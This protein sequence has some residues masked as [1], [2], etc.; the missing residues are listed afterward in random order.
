[1]KKLKMKSKIPVL[2]DELYDFFQLLLKYDKELNFTLNN[3]VWIHI[4]L[5]KGVLPMIKFE[6]DEDEWVGMFGSICLNRVMS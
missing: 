1:M 2:F 3:G 6:C 4:S 5:E